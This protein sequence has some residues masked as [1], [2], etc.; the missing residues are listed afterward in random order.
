[1]PS[2]CKIGKAS[3]AD[4]RNPARS[5]DRPRTKTPAA[6]TGQRSDTHRHWRHRRS[7]C[8]PAKACLLSLPANVHT[9]TFLSS[10][11]DEKS[12]KGRRSPTKGQTR[13]AKQKV[14]VWNVHGTFIASTNQNAYHS[15]EYDAMSTDCTLDAY[16]G[17]CAATARN[18]PA[19]IKQRRQT[20]RLLFL[21]DGIRNNLNLCHNENTRKRIA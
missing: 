5:P 7:I 13:P 3:A 1:M 10:P 4:A 19:T 6:R 2:R 15:H 14:T 12:P 21:N 20:N 11:D 18:K 8:E 17:T 9:Y 16:T